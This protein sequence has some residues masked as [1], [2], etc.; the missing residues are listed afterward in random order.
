[1]FPINS[2]ACGVILLW[3]I[4]S[5][6]VKRDS[7]GLVGTTLYATLSIS[8]L[9]VIVGPQWAFGPQIADV[10]MH[11]SM[12]A[13]A[14]RQMALTHWWDPVLHYFFPHRKPRRRHTD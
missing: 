7:A 6:L 11:S 13:L 9:A 3:S 2:M 4:W 10:T 8:S 1:M 5:V 14:L 12:A